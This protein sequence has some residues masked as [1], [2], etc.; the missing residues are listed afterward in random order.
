MKSRTL[1]TILILVFLT[2]SIYA[3]KAKNKNPL[4]AKSISI[5]KNG[6]AFFIKEGKVKTK[7]GSYIMTENLPRAL[8]GTFW[9]HSPSNELKQVTSYTDLVT[10]TSEDIARSFIDLVQANKG[11][12]M[13][14]HI[15]KDEIYEGIPE[16]VVMKD[17][18]G[19]EKRFVNQ[20][21]IVF[22]TATD[23]LSFSPAEIR[24]IQFLEK[25]NQLLEKETVTNKHVLSVDFTT[26]KSEQNLEMM[27]LENGIN[28]TPTYLIEMTSDTKAK[29]SLRAE[30]TNNAED[31]DNTDVNFVVGIPNFR[32]ANKLSSLVDF[33]GMVYPNKNQYAL[34]NVSSNLLQTS[35]YGIDDASMTAPGTPMG[36]GVV[37]DADEDLYFYNVKNITLKNG[38][39]GQYPIFSKEIDIAHI[40]EC[41]MAQNSAT[42][43]FYQKDF[44][45]TPDN[46]NP[47]FHSIKVNNN[48]EFP[49]TTGSAMVMSSKSGEK[50][51][52]SQDMLNYTPMKGHSYV[53]LT[54][55]PDIKVKHA[56]KE[57]SREQKVRKVNANNGRYYYDL[58]TVEGK[59]KVRSFKDKKVDLNLKRIIY[60]ELIES[61]VKWLKAERVN[62]SADINKITDVCWETSLDPEE[63]LEITYSYQVYVQQYY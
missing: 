49:W 29:L 26:K 24:R 20:S 15:G 34:N 61:E 52:I 39:R 16:E 9:I 25:P 4:K 28:W 32:Y 42:T 19:E 59:I 58:V 48:L 55:A 56:E 14:I 6:S 38:G 31:I 62:R 21:I 40:Y 36:G 2:N 7:N 30:V 23:W 5:F 46:K 54:E 57:V 3:Q 17:V 27:Y 37:G 11:K 45:F 47:V 18:K 43:G 50:R 22:K 63:E 8:F 51:P 1:I 33:L 13:K 44:L 10:T 60:G 12:K 41:N 35:D 53:K